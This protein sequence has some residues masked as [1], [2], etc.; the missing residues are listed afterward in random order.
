MSSRSGARSRWR[1]IC[2][3]HRAE[4]RAETGEIKIME[5]EEELRVV[6]NNLKS[7]EVKFSFVCASVYLD[8]LDEVKTHGTFIRW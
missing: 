8:I 3:R 4:E 6:G 1:R 2:R 5:L 7:L